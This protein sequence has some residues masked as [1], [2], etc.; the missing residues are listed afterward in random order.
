MH[1]SKGNFV[2]LGFCS[3]RV[4]GTLGKDM[5]AARIRS[6]NRH[7]R[8]D[9]MEQPTVPISDQV[10]EVV[11]AA[12]EA[13]RVPPPEDLSPSAVA[14]SFEADALRTEIIRVGRKLWQRQY[15]DGNGGNISVRIG[16]RYVL[17]TPTMLSKGDLE[18]ADIC[19]SDMEG[20][21][22]AGD[23]P[24]TSEL[25]L[26]LA[27]YRSNSRA[28]S[29]V[30]CHPPY[31]TAFAMT[32]ST[33]PLGFSS[34]YEV[35]IGP[36]GMANYETPGTQAFAD[37]VQIL[38][39]EHNTILLRNHGVVCWSDTPTHAE[40]L[41]EI[42]DNYCKTYLIALQLGR[43]LTPIPDEK[44]QELLQLKRRMGLP[45]PRIARLP[46][47]SGP[48]GPGQA[49]LDRLVEQVVAKLEGRG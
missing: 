2:H 23:R 36:V 4:C 19:L 40:W 13:L 41:V 34:E 3:A 49:E 14:N 24:R 30:H 20:N 45:D 44:I 43:P 17:C 42:L 33:P 37:S 7:I 38:A 27:I 29:V 10:R 21:I 16:P 26:H 47:S 32:G 1:S 5:T 11:Q 15:V 8:E 39:N 28:R 9:H 25:L 48:V 31:A 6:R 46:E 22:L 12:M 18:P 35:F